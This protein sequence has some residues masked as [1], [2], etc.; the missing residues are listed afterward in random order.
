[1]AQFNTGKDFYS[2][3]STLLHNFQ[4][5]KTMFYTFLN[6]AR[7]IREMTRPFMRLRKLD[8]SQI[9]NVSDIFTP[10]TPTTSK[11]LPTDF[12]MLTKEA[13]IM[14]FDGQQTWLTYNEIPMDLQVQYKDM[15]NRF[16]IDHANGKYYLLGIVDRQYNIFMFYQAD[17]GDISDLT[18]WVNIPDRFR[19]GLVYDA[20]AMYELGVDY[21]TT[22]ARNAN[23]NAQKGDQIFDAM[24]KWD[25]N[26]QRSSVT[27]LDY[28]VLGDTPTFTNRKINMDD[29]N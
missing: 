3:A 6:T 24:C 25:D 15:S 2:L 4:M 14:L 23:M 26:L 27:T 28:P 18:T 17:Y 13:T 29:A 10:L 1:M 21:D 22:N 9:A 20:V 11:T 5:D 8:T 12:M 16:F 19:A 7:T